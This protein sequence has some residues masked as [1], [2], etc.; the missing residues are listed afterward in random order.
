MIG[1]IVTVLVTAASLLI[2]ARLSIGLDVD[3]T[4]S[5]LLA[6][7]V[8]GLLNATLRPLL[9]FLAFPITFLTLG[10]FA[11]VLNALVLYITAALVKGFHVRGFLHAIIASILLGILNGII[12]WV[13][14]FFGL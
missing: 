11:I 7:L 12:F 10:L 6:A 14:S 4:G 9:G 13:L 5:A 8:L 3:D 2:L 1:F